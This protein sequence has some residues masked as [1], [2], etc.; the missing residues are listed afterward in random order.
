MRSYRFLY[1]ALLL[2][3]IAQFLP[4]ILPD[5]GAWN[6]PDKTAV[7]GWLVTAVAWP[8]YLSNLTLVMGALL[9]FWFK[10]FQRHRLA[11]GSLLAFYL[12]TPLAT[13]LFR[14]AILDVGLGFY[15]WVGSYCAASLGVAIIMIQKG[16]TI[17]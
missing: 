2:F 9:V 15:F 8:F 14:D 3:V 12:L 1:L 5:M 4:A 17:K 11:L 13:W 7:P 6:T 16:Q 10:R